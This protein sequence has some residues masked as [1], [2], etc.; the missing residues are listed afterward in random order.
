MLRVYQDFE[1]RR[2]RD[3]P[4][5]IKTFFD[6]RRAY[7]NKKLTVRD[8]Y[9]MENFYRVV[10]SL[11]NFSLVVKCAKH[12]SKVREMVRRCEKI[13]ENDIHMLV[14][15]LHT[16]KLTFWFLD[17]NFWAK[18]QIS[19]PGWLADRSI[20]ILHILVK[21]ISISFFFFF[22]KIL[23]FSRHCNL[24]G[25]NPFS[26]NFL[27]WKTRWR[28]FID[29]SANQPGHEIW[30]FAQKLEFKNHTFIFACV[31]SW[32]TRGCHFRILFRIFWP[33][34]ALLTRVLYISW[35]GWH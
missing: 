29:R 11:V 12:L 22:L 31:T 27:F 5:I 9:S 24:A 3:L 16:Q 32:L 28:I 14:M 8:S 17:S 25:N 23:S 34:L 6:I 30:N 20:K 2:S 1:A 10:R 33:F 15:T 7:N 18:F 4:D 21:S 26:I 13:C 19:W 35:S